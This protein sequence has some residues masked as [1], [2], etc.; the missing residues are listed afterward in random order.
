MIDI[1]DIIVI[2]NVINKTYQ[3]TIEKVLME[4]MGTHWYLLDD[5]AYPSPAVKERRPGLVHPMFDKNGIISPLYNLILPM[6]FESTSKINF[7]FEEALRGRAFIQFPSDSNYSNHPHIDTNSPHLVCLYYV[8]DSDG[9][10]IIYNE[11][12]DDIQNWPGLDTSMLTIR[13][14]VSPRKGR[15]VLFNGKRYHNSSTPTKNKRCVINFD[16]TGSVCSD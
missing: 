15:V 14:Q 12:V 6:V 10:T 7:N 4:E 16:L 1:N 9:D 3:D 5:I 11:T 2:D 8:N 13:Q